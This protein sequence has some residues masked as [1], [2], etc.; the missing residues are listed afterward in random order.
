MKKLKYAAF[1]SVAAIASIATIGAAQALTVTVW[2]GY[3]NSP[4]AGVTPDQA[5]APAPAGADT[6]MFTWTGPINWVNNAGNNG[7]DNTQNLYSQFFTGG[8]ISGYS[9]SVGLSESAFLNTSMSSSGNSWYS[10]IQ[11]VGTTGGG[12]ATITHDDGASVY[13]G[14]NTL[15]T[16]P[17][18]T[19]AV[20]AS[21]AI[22]AG[23]FT[24]DYIE[25]NGSPSDLVFSVVPE[26]STWVMMALGFAGLGFAGYRSR[27][28]VSITA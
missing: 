23:A 13:Q 19:S 4:I 7:T 26:P 15:Y 16:W 14:L 5:A 27:K 24:I 28:A 3:G 18:Q 8:T 11:V 17:T 6:A 2:G 25:A 21:F 12:E 10:Y 22:G 1:G 9:S 20:T